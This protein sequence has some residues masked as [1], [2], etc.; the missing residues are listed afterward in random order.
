MKNNRFE[1]IIYF[2]KKAISCE[3]LP[4]SRP[5][6]HATAE[7]SIKSQT[8]TNDAERDGYITLKDSSESLDYASINQN[9]LVATTQHTKNYLMASHSYHTTPKTATGI[10][11]V[12]KR[13]K[14]AFKSGGATRIQKNHNDATENHNRDKLKDKLDNRAED[15]D[16]K[17][18]LDNKRCRTDNEVEKG[19][20]FH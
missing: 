12:T 11:V 16:K 17:K 10:F 4:Q 13:I 9:Y 2:V 19:R 8:G 3:S 6:D 5:Q 14:T 20:F 1:R 7:V 15:R 18:Y